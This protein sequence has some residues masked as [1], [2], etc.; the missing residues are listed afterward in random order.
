MNN[1][2]FVHV[3]IID[4]QIY[5]S[6]DEV[7]ESELKKKLAESLHMFHF[8]THSIPESTSVYDAYII[9]DFDATLNIA[10]LRQPIVINSVNDTLEEL[11]LP[12]NF[13]RM[14]GWPGF[15]EA[16]KWEM[17]TNDVEG[18][19]NLM[20]Q[21]NWKYI[22]VPDIQGLLTPRIISQIINEAH[23][24][25]EDGIS[26]KQEIDMAMKLGTNYPYGPFEWTEKIG[27][28]KIYS[29]LAKLSE[30]DP[31]YLPSF[32]TEN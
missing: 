1:L 28:E 32:T 10:H 27:K 22:Q 31:R 24:A 4:M 15:I 5:V 25:L 23:F 7:Q 9:L 12:T 26:S 21:L 17:A 29:L 30:S 8:G 2:I 13:H 18:L 11:S 3:K 19:K 14:N 20:V 6:C 16:E